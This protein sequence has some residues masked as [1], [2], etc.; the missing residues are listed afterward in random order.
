[1]EISPTEAG[2]Q[3]PQTQ[4]Y[5]TKQRI[6]NSFF[7]SAIAQAELQKAEARQGGG[8]K[9]IKKVIIASGNLQSMATGK[10]SERPAHH[11]QS[12]SIT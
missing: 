7:E 5:A 12:K 4:R 10:S 9:R 6:E 2:S 11:S 3:A 8:I 1:M